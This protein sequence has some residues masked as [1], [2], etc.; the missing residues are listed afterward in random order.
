MPSVDRLIRALAC[1]VLLATYARG[2]SAEPLAPDQLEF[3]ERKVRPVLVEHCYSCHSA[4]AEKVKGD[5]LLDTRDGIRRG[6]TSGKAA[7]VPGDAERSPLVHAIRGDDPDLQ[8]PP[9]KRLSTQQIADLA[10]WVNMGAPDPRDGAGR[11]AKAPADAK[12]FWSFQPPREQAVPSVKDGAWARNDAD[13]FILAKLESENLSPSPEADR[14]TLIRRATYDLTGLPPTAG[15]VDAFLADASADAYERLIDRLLASPRYGERW[16]RHWLDL[17]RYSDTKGYVY[18]GREERRFVHS[19]VYRDYVIRAFNEDKPYDRFLLEQIAADQLDYPDT[20]TRQRAQAAM[21]FLTLGRRFLGVVPDIVDDRIDVVTRTTLGLTVACARCHDHK[22]DPIP[23]ADY[24]AL[25]GVFQGSTERCVPTD[26]QPART[27]EYE[28]YEAGLNERV[29]KLQD[30]FAAKRDAFEAKLRAKSVEYLTA[31][32]EA[33]KLPPDVF[34]ELRDAEDLIPTVVRQWQRYLMRSAGANDPIFAPWHG[35]AELHA[36]DA[37]TPDAAVTEMERLVG[38]TRHPVNGHVANAL[39]EAKPASMKDVAATYGRLFVEAE[40]A[41]KELLAKDPAATALP[42]RD[43]EALRQVL[44]GPATPARIPQGSLADV[45]W[46]FD[47]STRVELGKLYKDIENWHITAPGAV[48]QAV[49]LEDKPE[50][51]PPRVFKRGNPSTPGDEVPRGFLTALSPGAGPAPFATGSGRLELARAIASPDNPLTARV[52]VNRLWAH[53]FGAGLVDTPSDFGVRSEPPSHP[54]LLDWL[55][56]RFVDEG[57]SVKQMHRLM[58]TS[59]TYRQASADDANP[60]A[61]AADPQNRLLWRMNRARLDFEGMRD[62]LLAVSGGLD[63]AMG[64]PPADV[65]TG[66]RS[67]Y[68]FV[69]R[70]FLP[71]V[72]RV[73]DFANP[74]LHIPQRGSTTVPQQALFFMNGRFVAERAKALAGHPEV[75]NAPDDAERVRRLYRMV[76]QR[77]ATEGQVTAGVEFVRSADAPPAEPPPAPVATAWQYGFGAYDSSADRVAGFTALPHFNGSAW[78]GGPAWP[79]A[80]L[81]WVQLTATGGHAGDDLAHAAVRRWVAPRDMAIRISGTVIHKEAPGDGVAARLLSSRHGT[82]GQW[83]LHNTT[84]EATVER[85]EVKQGDTIDFVIDILGTLN[86]DM[87]TWAPTITSVDPAPAGGAQAKW[88]AAREF[89]GPSPP[90]PDPLG[91]WAMYAQVLLL[92]NEFVFVD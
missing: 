7:I 21:G 31:V 91:P 5:F 87:F 29:K 48:P 78:Q 54:E 52:M 49:V 32:L 53:H 80:A 81:G 25:Y 34:Y 18:E 39:T 63:P 23:T 38:M 70:Q 75:A 77:P 44:Y 50:Q 51:R 82:L 85:L 28:K 22:F 2:A 16:G 65:S 67:V 55:A 4:G 17:A 57:W 46:Y 86:N 14:R 30:T 11:G 68:L 92:S 69:D 24:Y 90:P 40:N 59:A 45:E 6:G 71:G 10:A 20:P 61:A 12:N 56:L 15:E 42:D 19:H 41:W 1:L 3:F 13:R 60:A 84:A 72:F 58:M 88:D 36:R 43:R 27:P 33:D 66:R 8:M 26:L 73:F 47:E 76:Y 37:L 89:G 9:E 62:S 83:N 74:D 79:D 64:G 35:L